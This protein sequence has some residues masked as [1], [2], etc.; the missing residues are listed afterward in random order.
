[1]QQPPGG[2]GSGDDGV[3]VADAVA[4]TAALPRDGACGCLPL[5]HQDAAAVRAGQPGSG[6]QSRRSGTGDRNLDGPLDAADGRGAHRTVFRCGR[7]EY[8]P[9]RKPV[10]IGHSVDALQQDVQVVGERHSRGQHG[11]A[12][13][14]DEDVPLV[15]MDVNE[16]G[17][18]I[19]SGPQ[20]GIGWV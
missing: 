17:P 6:G 15:G 16:V 10:G 11:G 14:A 2:V 3:Q 4:E 18:V 19:G 7:A 12:D 13:T 20:P 1:V 9:P 8:G 5:E